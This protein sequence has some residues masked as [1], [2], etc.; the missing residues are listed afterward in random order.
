MARYEDA[1]PF[2]TTNRAARCETCCSANSLTP[3][4]A[5]Y[6]SGKAAMPPANVVSIRRV[7]VLEGRKAA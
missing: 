1:C 5:A 4:V 6:L 3:C 7:E 2:E